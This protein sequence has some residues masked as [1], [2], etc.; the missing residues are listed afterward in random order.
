MRTLLLAPLLAALSAIPAAAGD[1]HVIVRDF[2]RACGV[3]RVHIPLFGLARFAVSVARPGGVKEF[4]VAIF[5]TGV[6]AADL[7]RFDGIMRRVGGDRWSGVIRVRS[8]RADGQWVQIY[9]RPDG[10]DWRMLIATFGPAQT[11]LLEARVNP[12]F[13]ARALEH[14]GE[15]DRSFDIDP[16]IG[17][18]A[19]SD[20]ASQP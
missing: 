5:E 11:V 13:L 19:T 8:R 9:V 15:A 4:D 2:E 16:G 18:A 17:G 7:S 14:P 6:S 3:Q 10:G 1:F 20:A 12:E